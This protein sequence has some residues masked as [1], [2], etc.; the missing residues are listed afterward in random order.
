MA[1][2][3][4]FEQ[5]TFI[6]WYHSKN[7]AQENELINKNLEAFGKHCGLLSSDDIDFYHTEKMNYLREWYDNRFVPMFWTLTK[8]IEQQ[9]SAG[10]GDLVDLTSIEIN[11][12]IFNNIATLPE[13]EFH[14]LVLAAIDELRK[15]LNRVKDITPSLEGYKAWKK[16]NHLQNQLI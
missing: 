3:K 4:H 14:A 15:Q 2:L 5:W 8:V 6:K 12:E 9:H 7:S 13:P 11:G 1:S 10:N 16:K